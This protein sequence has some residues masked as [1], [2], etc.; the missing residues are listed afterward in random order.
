MA[1]VSTT[2][3]EAAVPAVGPAPQAAL[4]R[5]VSIDFLRGLVMVIM[6]L[7][8]ARDFWNGFRVDPT[9]LATTTPFLFATRVVTHFCAPVFILLS[10]TAA[11]LYGRR[12]SGPELRRFLLTR[13]LFLIALEL[14]VVHFGWIPAFGHHWIPLQVI[15]AIGWSMVCLA[16]LS[17]LP[18]PVLVALSAAVVL[19][20]NL[21]DGVDAASFGGGAWLWRIL[22]QPGPIAL[23]DGHVAQVLYPL[24]PWIFVM[25]LGYALGAVMVLPAQ[26][27]RTLL[28]AIGCSL[29]AAFL[30]LRGFNLYGDPRPWLPQDSLLLRAMAFVNTTKYPPS[31]LYLCMTLGPAL[32]LLA[33]APRADAAW[34]KALVTFG[35][36][37]LLFYVAHL[38]LLRYPAV[39]VALTRFGE[40]GAQMAP[41]GTMGSPE[42]PLWTAYAAWAVAIALLYPLCK[43]YAQ[44]KA[45]GSSPWLRYL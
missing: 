18:L 1:S 5:D 34:V 3:Q 38:Y 37:P 31:L 23:A 25:A 14:T 45:T 24:V 40:R 22:H 16:A 15:W 19:G 42:L 39:P 4:A 7:D 2:V 6:A 11:Y 21:L 20:H 28:T 43:R 26:R 33:Y 9:D 35:R 41:E 17:A 8:H 44:L 13:G 32:L 29:I 10:G 30:L 12:A 36:V 27:R